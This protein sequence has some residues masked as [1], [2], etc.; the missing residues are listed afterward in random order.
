VALPSEN[1]R[2]IEEEEEER[3]AEDRYRAEI[4]AKQQGKSAPFSKPRLPWI[5]GI[6]T[7]LVVGAIVWWNIAGRKLAPTSGYAPSAQASK[8]TPVLQTRYVPVDQ[9]IASGQILVRAK[10]HVHYRL[11]I[12]PEM[13]ESTVTGTFKASGGA[14]NDITAVI[15]DEENY[16]NWINGHQARVFWSTQG[17]ETT[18]NFEVHLP[19]GIYY[20]ALSNKFSTFTDKQVFL[21]ADLNYKKSETY[22]D[23]KVGQTEVHPYRVNVPDGVSA[24]PTH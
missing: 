20:L 22:N 11:T 16:T 15:A 23:D 19:P 12:T 6:G 10:G 5:A 8:P 3:A 9:K 2:R 24:H 14:G 1:I 4:R 7:I 17:R 18:G 13:M 21:E